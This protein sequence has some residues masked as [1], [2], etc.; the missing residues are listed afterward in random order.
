M[1]QDDSTSQGVILPLTQQWRSDAFRSLKGLLGTSHAF[2]YT[3]QCFHAPVTMQIVWHLKAV[4]AALLVLNWRW[5]FRAL[6]TVTQQHYASLMVVVVALPVACLLLSKGPHKQEPAKDP[7]LG[8]PQDQPLPPK[9]FECRT[10][11]SRLFPQKHSFSYSYL[12]VGVPIGWRGAV[13]S[14]LSSD[15]AVTNGLATS[16]KTWFSV[17]AE[18]YLERGGHVDGLAGKLKDYLTAQNVSIDDYPYAYLVTA[19]RFLGFSFNPVSFWYLYDRTKEL[20]AMILEVNNTF[21]E[22]RMYFLPRQALEDDAQASRRFAQHWDKDFHVSPFNDREG[23]YSLSAVDP[24]ETKGQIDNNLVLSSKDGKPKI[25]ARVYSPKPG[26][27]PASMSALNTISFL[28]RW[29]W[30]GFMTNPRII[31]EARVLWVKGLQVFYRPEVMATSI[32]RTPSTGE[33]SIE[34]VFRSW[35]KDLSN[36]S[37][38]PIRYT[39]AANDKKARLICPG[40]EDSA[41]RAMAKQEVLEIKILTPAF[42]AEIARDSDVRRVFER[43]C[44]KAGAGEAMAQISNAEQFNEILKSFERGTLQPSK[45]NLS[46]S[47]IQLLRSGRCGMLVAWLQGKRRS[48]SV[49]PSGVSPGNQSAFLDED[50]KSTLDS[51]QVLDYEQACLKVLLADRF[52][53]GLTSLLKLYVRLSWLVAFTSTI[54]HLHQWIHGSRGYESWDICSFGMKALVMLLIG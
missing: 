49:S 29:W 10:D 12:L 28:A 22:R 37:D 46:S 2:A 8:L 25:I 47:I 34:S 17:H 11:H 53:F 38:T 14:V 15:N 41:Q 26:L 6:R 30:V 44:Y 21:D 23:S 31:R 9:I 36:F 16:S 42:Y 43:V 18:D 48:S 39:P 19:P 3:K 13:G 24:L 52:A 5:A 4:A 20:A 50:L 33:N 32:G 54:S 1:K 40:K 45:I 51:Q 27:N 7:S 35:L